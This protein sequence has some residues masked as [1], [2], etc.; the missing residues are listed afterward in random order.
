VEI[1][2]YWRLNKQRYSLVGS[3]C[4]DCGEKQ[5]PPRINCLKSNG[6]GSGNYKDKNPLDN[7]QVEGSPNLGINGDKQENKPIKESGGGNIY[8]SPTSS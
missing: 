8:Q 7:L 3:L 4:S 6:D 2:R 1:P 5:F